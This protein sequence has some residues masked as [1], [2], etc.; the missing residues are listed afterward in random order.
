MIL[1]I[2]RGEDWQRAQA[3]GA[4]APESLEREGFVHFSTPAQVVG[5]AARYYAGQ[6]GLLLL[7][8]D[9]AAL[10]VR[11]RWE[12]PG[13]GEPFPHLYGPLPLDAVGAVLPFEP[14]DQGRF[15][16]PSELA[17]DPPARQ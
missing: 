12:D 2:L 17:G 11:L 13:H 15:S 1:H 4:Y 10:G 6:R 16:L 14:D 7:V 3:T 8:V 9:P 5:T